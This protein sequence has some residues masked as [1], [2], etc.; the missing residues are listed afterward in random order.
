MYAG[1]K[2]QLLIALKKVFFFKNIFL[3]SENQ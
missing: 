1:Q 2:G 3:L